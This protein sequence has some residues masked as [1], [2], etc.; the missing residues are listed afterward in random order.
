MLRIDGFIDRYFPDARPYGNPVTDMSVNCPFC[1]DTKGHLKISLE[2]QVCHCFRCDY[3]ASWVK[4]VMDVT[5][6]TYYQAMNE[7]YYKP[8]LSDEESVIGKLHH[9]TNVLDT[10][11]V[12]SKL[13][14]D[15]E[16]LIRNHKPIARI[17]R[18]YIEERGFS[19][20]HIRKYNLGMSDAYP[21]RVIIPIEEGYWQGRGIFPWIQP[22]YINPKANSRG[23]IFNAKA[24]EIFDE[25]VVCEGAFSAMAVGS[26]AI[27]LVGKEVTKEKQSRILNS[28]VKRIIIALE[29]G[30][31]GSMQILMDKAVAMSKEV[32]VW[33]YNT[34][35]PADSVDFEVLEY[36]LKTK[37]ALRLER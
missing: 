29:E 37:V 20:Y 33:K 15:F 35:D 32:I 5:K 18:G 31:Y 2:K 19:S 30:A 26:N 11:G 4:L 23:I 10:S 6:F 24:L 14:N 12:V 1:G 3:K 22:K 36:N 25:I 28:S 9:K 16:L 7:L 27:A 8:K 34:G 21:L 13:P 17:L